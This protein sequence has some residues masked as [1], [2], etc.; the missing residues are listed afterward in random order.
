VHLGPD[1]EEEDT[2]MQPTPAIG[3]SAPDTIEQPKRASQRF[4]K[5]NEEPEKQPRSKPAKRKK[6]AAA[7][8]AGVK[9]SDAKRPKLNQNGTLAQKRG[10]PRIH[11]IE[12]TPRQPFQEEIEGEG[13]IQ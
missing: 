10:R 3:G 2:F 7:G 9:E 6:S 4:V 12:E 11:P 13:T 1:D 5:V 8:A